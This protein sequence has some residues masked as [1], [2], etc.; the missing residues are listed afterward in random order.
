MPMVSASLFFIRT[1]SDLI[2]GNQSTVHSVLMAILTHWYAQLFNVQLNLHFLPLFLSTN[3]LVYLFISRCSCLRNKASLHETYK[4]IWLIQVQRS[5]PQ[6][7][8]FENSFQIHNVFY[9]TI[10]Q[11]SRK[12]VP[13]TFSPPCA[14][15]V[16]SSKERL[17]YFTLQLIKVR[18]TTINELSYVRRITCRILGRICALRCCKIWRTPDLAHPRSFTD[19]YLHSIIGNNIG[20][21]FLG[22]DRTFFSPLGTGHELHFHASF[23]IVLITIIKA[24]V[25]R[26]GYFLRRLLSVVVID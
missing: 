20:G 21:Y 10:P 2:K 6:D 5:P 9:V 18:D 13:S 4:K 11:T 3:F 12:L 14:V 25:S 26:E 17:L 15:Q 19:L 16:A 23:G 8:H 24:A 22:E 7:R 1:S